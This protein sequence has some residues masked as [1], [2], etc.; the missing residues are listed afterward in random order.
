MPQRKRFCGY[1]Y[2]PIT[3]KKQTTLTDAND[4]RQGDR[5]NGGQRTGQQPN[6]QTQCA[7]RDAS[8]LLPLL[9]L[10]LLMLLLLWRWRP[11]IAAMR[12]AA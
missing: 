5:H 1:K 6:E 11:L 8:P 3:R 4:G 12:L 7:Q 10:L 2:A 9:P